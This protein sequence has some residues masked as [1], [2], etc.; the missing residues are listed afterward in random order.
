M[1][2]TRRSNNLHLAENDVSQNKRRR[3]ARGSGG[4]KCTL[5]AK[6][7][8]VQYPDGG[9]Y[10]AVLSLLTPPPLPGTTKA[11]LAVYH[12]GKKILMVLTLEAGIVGVGQRDQ[13]RRLARL[14]GRVVENPFV[15]VTIDV[16]MK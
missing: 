4:G 10:H 12:Q 8:S 13:L 14:A 16:L 3:A 7:M 9:H 15:S 1:Q 2:A 11:E 5:R 6:E